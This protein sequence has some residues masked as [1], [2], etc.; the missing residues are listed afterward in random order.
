VLALC[1]KE[2]KLL[3]F[4]AE[5]MAVQGWRTN[6]VDI[7][8]T[9]LIV[10][11]IIIGL[12]T[13]GVVLMSAMLVAPAAAARQ[14]SNRLGF[15]VALAALFGALSGVIGAGLSSSI[16]RLSTGPTIVLVVSAFVLISL[17]LAPARGMLWA[18]LRHRRLHREV[19]VK[20][21]LVG[22]YNLA[23]HH[24]DPYYPHSADTLDAVGVH[25][26]ENTLGQLQQRGLVERSGSDWRLT[27]DGVKEAEAQL[28]AGGAA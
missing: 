3:S 9:T 4:D 20:T 10:V 22:L 17:F 27:A 18:H 1:F 6:F 5:F 16:E 19:E 15:V 2:F 8:L 11:A 26:A 28:S 24:D 14:W 7:L 23:G 25:S 12:Q 21:V 13:V